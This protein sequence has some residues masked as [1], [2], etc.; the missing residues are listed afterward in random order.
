MA[1]RLRV[2]T[3]RTA[4][5]VPCRLTGETLFNM[6]LA[7]PLIVPGLFTI[8]CPVLIVS[9]NV[10]RSNR[11]SIGMT[12]MISALLVLVI[13][14]PKI[15]R[16]LRDSVPVVLVLQVA[17]LGLRWHL[18]MVNGTLVLRRVITVRA[19]VFPDPAPSSPV[20]TALMALLRGRSG[21]GPCTF[22]L[23]L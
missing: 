8:V 4:G 23:G 7:D 17:A 1:E 22:A 12:V 14:A 9:V 21:Y 19:E 10:P 13:R 2:E 6:H 18:R 11:L 5:R 15:C 3:L 16:G 20:V